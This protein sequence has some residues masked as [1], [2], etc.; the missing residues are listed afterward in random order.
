MSDPIVGLLQSAFQQRLAS[1]RQSLLWTWIG[2][3][4][5][6]ISLFF[7]DR[8]PRHLFDVCWWQTATFALAAWRI[9]A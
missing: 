2:C 5:A 3:M 1:Q 6:D 8:D 9:G 4:I 7:W